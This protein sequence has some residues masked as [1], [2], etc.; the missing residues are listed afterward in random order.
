MRLDPISLPQQLNQLTVPSLL[1]PT[2]HLR[3]LQQNPSTLPITSIHRTRQLEDPPDP[4]LDD[5]VRRDQRR[6]L[7][8][9]YFR[10]HP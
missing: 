4:L 7:S 2:H 3:H 1:T 6:Q 10:A 5:R 9:Q 8:P